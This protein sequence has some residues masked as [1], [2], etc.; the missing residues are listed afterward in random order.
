MTISERTAV[1]ATWRA[2]SL[3]C[4]PSSMTRVNAVSGAGSPLRSTGSR[5]SQRSS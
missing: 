5:I 4:E 2:R 1:P 3:T